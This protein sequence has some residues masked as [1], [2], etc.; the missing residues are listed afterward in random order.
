MGL[1]KCLKKSCLGPGPQWTTCA[2]FSRQYNF[3]VITCDNITVIII[4][5][6]L[7]ISDWIGLAGSLQ[8]CWYQEHHSDESLVAVGTTQRQQETSPA[9]CEHVPPGHCMAKPRALSNRTSAISS[10]TF[11][12]FASLV[13]SFCLFCLSKITA[14]SKHFNERSCMPGLLKLSWKCTSLLT[15]EAD[16]GVN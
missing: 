10:T 1:L 2:W 7:L 4:M 15:D 12:L 13:A 8:L 5:N 16:L 14:H 6:F 3:T 11:H 9:P